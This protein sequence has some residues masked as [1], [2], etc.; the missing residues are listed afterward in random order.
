MSAYPPEIIYRE[1]KI[2]DFPSLREI[3]HQCLPLP[4]PDTYWLR[5]ASDANN[6]YSLG[7]YN[8]QQ[9]LVGVIGVIR[10][11][12]N[13]FSGRLLNPDEQ[14]LI[15]S[16]SKVCYITT[17]MVA[18][19][20]RKKGIATQLLQR[21]STVLLQEGRHLLYLHV[22]HSNV[23]AIRLY[24]KMGYE[25]VTVIADYYTIDGQKQPGVVY[26]RRLVAPMCHECIT[27]NVGSCTIL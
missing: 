15:D 12:K 11:A 5:I 26:C 4:Y 14:K 16:Y 22:L 2:D 19:D 1:L 24:E 13:Y 8:K 7:A 21:A 3:G 17:L 10:Y 20:C 9:K 25:K 18:P 23:P 27:N 6:Y